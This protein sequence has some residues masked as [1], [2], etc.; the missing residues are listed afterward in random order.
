MTGSS[1]A[2]PQIERY[3]NLASEGERGQPLP[4][5]VRQEE[6]EGRRGQLEQQDDAGEGRW[7]R[8]RMRRG[9]TIRM[10]SPTSSRPG[11]A[12]HAF[13]LA[14]VAEALAAARRSCRMP[15]AAPPR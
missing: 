10:C 11:L 6:E 8:G 7:R 9:G 14:D 1:V 4:G 12:A 2:T 13:W 5:S 15:L 3:E